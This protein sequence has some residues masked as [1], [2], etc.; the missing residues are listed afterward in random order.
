MDKAIY[1]L[2]EEG[3]FIG[4]FV[5]TLYRVKLETVLERL[6]ELVPKIK[7]IGRNTKKEALEEYGVYKRRTSHGNFF[8][9][10][11]LKVM[12]Q[13]WCDKYSVY[14]EEYFDSQLEWHITHQDY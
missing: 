7:A 11:S 14:Y 3:V 12:R 4:E 8:I 5:D 1:H 10:P 13:K 9:F 2:L 6:T